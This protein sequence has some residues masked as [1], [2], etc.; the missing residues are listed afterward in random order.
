ME[1]YGISRCM[2]RQHPDEDN[3]SLK[4]NSSDVYVVVVIN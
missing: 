3:K 4:N 2:R 1:N